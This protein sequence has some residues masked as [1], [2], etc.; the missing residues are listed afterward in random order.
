MKKKEEEAS[1]LCSIAGKFHLA[2]A[3]STI[4]IKTGTQEENWNYRRECNLV[5]LL[6]LISFDPFTTAR[7][8]S[9]SL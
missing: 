8:L 7:N 5:K 2:L 9:Y 4:L 6:E 3:G 1:N